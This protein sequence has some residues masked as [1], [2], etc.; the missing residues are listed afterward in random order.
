PTVASCATPPPGAAPA[1]NIRANFEANTTP[2]TAED[3]PPQRR[4]DAS[5]RGPRGRRVGNGRLVRAQRWS[6]RLG[7]RVGRDMRACTGRGAAARGLAECD[8]A[9]AGEPAHQYGGL[10]HQHDWRRA[11]PLLP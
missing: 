2:D 8:S 7:P 10:R 9:R 6:P 4:A 1:R 5:R 3:A 11:E